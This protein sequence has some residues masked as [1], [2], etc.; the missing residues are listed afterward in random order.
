[1]RATTSST[2]GYV[3]SRISGPNP[4]GASG[5]CGG[6]TSTGGPVGTAGTGAALGAVAGSAGRA[7]AGGPA[8]AARSRL[9]AT[10]AGR[11]RRS[12]VEGVVSLMTG[13]RVAAF[14]MT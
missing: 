11:Q 4:G 10:A 13:P 12:G 5:V 3:G 7:A 2:A 8:H 14:G 6:T 1:M 9:T